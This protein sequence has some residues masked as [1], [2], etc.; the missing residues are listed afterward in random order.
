[1]GF[2]VRIIM[3]KKAQTLP[4]LIVAIG[5]LMVIYLYFLP[6]Q[7]KCKIMPSLV[8]C[9][10]QEES[11]FSAVP[12]LLE[13]KETAARYSFDTIQLFRREI[14]ET[15]EVFEN[16]ATE[17]SWFSSTPQRS[18][19]K[20]QEN[21]KSAVLYIFVSKSKG[22]LK[23]YLNG[24]RISTVKGEGVHEIA[25]DIDSL[26][27]T[28]NLEV[29]PSMPLLPFFKNSYE[30]AKAVLKEDYIITNNRIEI[31]FE[32]KEEEKDIKDITLSF[33][34]DCFSEKP[35]RVLIDKESV[36][37][38]MACGRI[39]RNVT[40][41]V[42][43]LNRTG[44]MSFASDGNYYIKNIALDVRM[45]EKDWPTYYFSIIQSKLS[46]PTRLYIKFED[47]G[48]KKLTAYVNGN[49]LAVEAR[50]EEWQAVINPYLKKGQNSIAL[51]PEKTVN[52]TLLEVR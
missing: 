28:N 4:M 10:G 36:Y 20:I 46:K 49:A 47:H 35:L 18:V 38:N 44:K 15:S 25:L 50:G 29:V 8:E 32:V 31:P 33:T 37:D 45:K 22:S 26:D 14:L 1:M 34:S 9:K 13:E 17:Q 19:L 43:E 5:I 39:S 16:A 41:E 23:V 48:Q 2:S 40:H 6:L 7:E 30:I 21:G 3:L 11:I 51:I 42:L 52:V 24:Q 12:G 27:E